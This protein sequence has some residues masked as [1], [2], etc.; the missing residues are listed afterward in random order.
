MV[1]GTVLQ[2]LLESSP[3]SNA[4]CVSGGSPNM[5]VYRW[6]GTLKLKSTWFLI[7][8]SWIGSPPY[9]YK[10]PFELVNHCIYPSDPRNRRTRSIATHIRYLDICPHQIAIIQLHWAQWRNGIDLLG[11]VAN[12][13]LFI[14]WN[15]E[16]LTENPSSLDVHRS[17]E[18]VI[19]QI[20]M[21]VH[22]GE[23]C[24]KNTESR[25]ISN[26]IAYRQRGRVQAENGGR[27]WI[28]SA[29]GNVALH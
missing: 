17:I 1:Q 6:E 7:T 9:M 5:I 15:F 13:G 20:R 26:E 16:D 19:E 10:I 14:M 18:R 23:D 25:S 22:R 29:K 12:L 24:K 28:T 8:F 27:W 3:P 2:R 4:G 21:S 11:V